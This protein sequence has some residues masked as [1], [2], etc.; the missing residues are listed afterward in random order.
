MLKK[1]YKKLKNYRNNRLAKKNSLVH[2]KIMEK[3]YRDGQIPWSPGYSDHKIS[4]IK[5]NILDVK[6]QENLLKGVLPKQ[7][8]YR[9]D[10]RIVEYAWIFSHISK[11][12]ERM[13][14]AGSTFNFPHIIE[15][16]K[17]KNKD[18]II[19]T[20]APEKYVFNN[21][22]ISY[23]YGDLREI[24]LR[25]NY[26]D[27]IVSQSTIE[28]IDM[29]NSMYGYELEHNKNEVKKSYD[30]MIA[31]QEMIRVLKPG[32]TL[33]LTFPFGKF[34]HHGFFQQID[35]EMIQRMYDVFEKRGNYLST[36]FKYEID[37][38]CFSKMEELDAVES[39]NPHTGKG[40]KDDFAAHSRAIACVKFVKNE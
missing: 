6:L 9:L 38:W 39:Y 33:L 25:D 32:G 21:R 3:Y 11:V 19:F 12:K 16:P 40:L 31:I 23:V 35:K 29:D 18:L 5:K 13:L 20:Y 28:H 17:I 8:G 14:D 27:L 15:H 4:M 37:G 2:N 26:F 36:F 10:E 22:R 34:E 7:Y 30:Y 24:C 1:I